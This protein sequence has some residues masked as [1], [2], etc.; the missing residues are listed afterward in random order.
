MFGAFQ[1]ELWL[2]FGAAQDCPLDASAAERR[3]ERARFA[4]IAQSAVQLARSHK[5]EVH[6]CA[7]AALLCAQLGLNK[8]AEELLALSRDEAGQPA[9]EPKDG[10][11]AQNQVQMR[12]LAAALNVMS[13]VTLEKPDTKIMP[14]ALRLEALADSRAHGFGTTFLNGVGLLALAD[15]LKVCGGNAPAQP[16]P[17]ALKLNGKIAAELPPGVDLRRMTLNAAA[18]EAAFRDEQ[19][20]KPFSAGWDFS[21]GAPAGQSI[22]VAIERRTLLPERF[23]V[24]SREA[25]NARVNG[26]SNVLLNPE[27]ELRSSNGAP[28]Q[29]VIRR[30]LFVRAPNPRAHAAQDPYSGWR[31]Y[32]G[33]PIPVGTELLALTAVLYAPGVQ[34]LQIELPTLAGWESVQWNEEPFVNPHAP[35]AGADIEILSREPGFIDAGAFL[36]RENAARGFAA[37][38]LRSIQARNWADVR[39]TLNTAKKMPAAQFAARAG[40]LVVSPFTSFNESAAANVGENHGAIMLFAQSGALRAAGQYRLPG[41]RAWAWYDPAID[42][43]GAADRVEIAAD[44]G[45]LDAPDAPFS[46]EWLEKT[47]THLSQ[48][49]WAMPKLER[50]NEPMHAAKFALQA[51]AQCHGERAPALVDE[52]A[53][54]LP[55][56]KNFAALRE[57]REFRLSILRDT[58]LDHARPEIANALL[59]PFASFEGLRVECSAARLTEDQLP[60]LETLLEWIKSEKEDVKALLPLLPAAERVQ[61]AAFQK[62]T[63]REFAELF[64]V[65]LWDKP[66]VT[67]AAAA[68]DWLWRQPAQAFLS[69]HT[70]SLDQWVKTLRESLGFE[71]QIDPRSPLVVSLPEP[72]DSATLRDY[73]SN[74]LA[75]CGIAAANIESGEHVV[76]HRLD[77]PSP[78]FAPQKNAALAAQGKPLDARVALDLPLFSAGQTQSAV[79]AVRQ[80]FWLRGIQLVAPD[81][82]VPIKGET[83]H[84]FLDSL[85]RHLNRAVRVESEIIEL[86]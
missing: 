82:D 1:R 37:H 21:I 81:A 65:P 58:G 39:R 6:D 33:Q 14:L 18:V 19:N 59:A 74:Q 34:C 67:P 5:F 68:R 69:G 36:K 83:L 38:V 23:E 53:K 40:C 32:A 61:A 78:S 49:D 77:T 54:A 70:G 71:I 7:L 24:L 47:W 76:L 79:S 30:T 57:L 51:L 84:V 13:A 11:S 50:A 16:G 42:V 62:V 8:D 63:V 80:A 48:T 55:Q 56:P 52:W 22:G 45:S 60:P 15:A 3:A 73:L 31:P 43:T 26:F 85:A 10:G 41:A 64:F 9:S 29:C 44:G 46:T 75:A 20:G 4:R 17:I 12:Q 28:S 35:E 86:K 66:A 72:G 25:L 2:A 27:A